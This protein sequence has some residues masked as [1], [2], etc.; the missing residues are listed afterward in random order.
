MQSYN[1]YPALLTLPYQMPR[2]MCA[3]QEESHLISSFTNLKALPEN[4]TAPT[5]LQGVQHVR[6]CVLLNRYLGGVS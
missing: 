3:A 6:G 5:A 1:T 4:P 2:G